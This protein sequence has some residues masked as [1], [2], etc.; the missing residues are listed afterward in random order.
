M[1][2]WE[3]EHGRLST[4]LEASRTQLL[5]GLH[6]GLPA[7]EPATRAAAPYPDRQPLAAITSAEALM[8]Q[9]GRVKLVDARA[10]E[11][12]RGEV[13]PLDPVAGH[14]PGARN[15]PYGNLFNADGT[16]TYDEDTVLQILGRIVRGRVRRPRRTG[17]TGRT[18]CAQG[19]G[20]QHR[21][22]ALRW[23]LQHRPRRLQPL[24]QR[25]DPL[26]QA[27]RAAFEHLRHG[28]TLTT[29]LHCCTGQQRQRR[30]SQENKK[31]RLSDR[32]DRRDDERRRGNQC[33][34]RDSS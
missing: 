16:W 32:T 22:H 1:A 28:Q 27:Q 10:G 8:A 14:I 21:A 17:R 18:G 30:E 12:F 25:L 29:E 34:Q 26:P 2:R 19:L 23:Q 5:A 11:R 15:L 9:L 31:D 7:F 20:V 6:T 33:Q 4:A 13:E 24:N 3:A